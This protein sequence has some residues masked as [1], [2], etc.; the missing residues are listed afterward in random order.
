VSGL[1]LGVVLG[2]VAAASAVTLALTWRRL[3]PAST[4]SK[5]V[6]V[7]LRLAALGCLAL[8]I[9][10]PTVTR[11]RTERRLPR[12]VLLADASASMGRRD[13]PGGLSRAEWVNRQVAAQGAVG[14][15][16]ASAE[17]QGLRFAERPSAWR[18]GEGLDPRG[19]ATDLEAALRAAARAFPDGRPDA[20]VL[21]SDGAA[22]AG[23]DR[24]ATLAWLAGLRMP[25][26]CVGV[27]SATPPADVW[28][29]RVEAPGVVKAGRSCAVVVGVSSR[30]LDGKTTSVSLSGPTGT[31]QPAPVTLSAGRLQSST[32]TL[33]P[34]RPGT[35]RCTAALRNTAGE[36]TRANNRRTFLLRVVPGEVK[37]LVVAGRPSLELK[38]LRR[39]LVSL[40]DVKVTWLIRKAGGGFAAPE[41]PAA[42]GGLP[43]GRELQ[44]YEAVML[45]D[46]PASALGAATAQALLSFVAE[47]G[48]SLAMLGGADGFGTGGWGAGPL[49]PALGVQVAAAAT[50]AGVPVKA[51]PDP[52]ATAPVDDITRA[53]GFPG[54]GWMPLLD[55]LNPSAV[56][57]PGAAIQLRAESGQPLLVV[58]R[59]G[60]GRTLCLLTGGT[61]R[62]ALSRDATDA[63]RRG[64][65]AFWQTLAVW[66]TTP[67][68]RTPVSLQTDREV[69]EVG[70]TARLIA[71]VTDQGFRPLS[72]ARVVVTASGPAKSR[73]EVH[74][75]ESP[76]APGR[77]EGGLALVQPGARNLT[78]VAS[79]RGREVGR[80][81]CGIEVQA[82]LAELADPAQDVEMLRALADASG[83]AYLPAE[84]V[85]DLASGLPLAPRSEQRRL[86]VAWARTG[87]LFALMVLLMGAEW[88][89]RRWRGVG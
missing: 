18:L 43:S 55:G 81:A 45:Q 24:E 36:W 31:L 60:A 25:V 6:L 5:V 1:Q 83:G 19:S 59:Y 64:H 11:T 17:T 29:S 34:E 61:H 53:A 44:A 32:F 4:P 88:L 80:D 82:P 79:L 28:L 71:Q 56:V 30:G 65:A 70:Q 63:S 7:A 76:D 23:R 27:G 69:Y 22:N 78:A 49:A 73:Q 41:G 62:W 57:R 33:R 86:A 66:L 50:Y 37:L 85:A 35:Y 87:S 38:L 75:A 68:G 20:V 54:W 72:G 8:A 52:D 14:R 77:Y 10:N 21:L 9:L 26:H 47:R 89:L 42:S 16:L 67:L 74:L 13:A 84:R 39:A 12:V 15:A 40:G 48:G 46:L 51:V 2:L 3:G 58:Q